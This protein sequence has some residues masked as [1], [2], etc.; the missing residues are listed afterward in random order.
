M[1]TMLYMQFHA[2]TN[3]MA[4]YFVHAGF[5]KDIESFAVNQTSLIWYMAYTM[6]ARTCAFINRTYKVR[7]F[8]NFVRQIYIHSI[9]KYTV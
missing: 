3:E 8:S 7:Y 1:Y 4:Y 2:C 6:Y 5:D 9:T